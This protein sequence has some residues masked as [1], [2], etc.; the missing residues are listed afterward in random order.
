M[1]QRVRRCRGSATV[2][3]VVVITLTVFV[4]IVI[5]VL[6]CTLIFAREV[7]YT[8][9]TSRLRSAPTQCTNLSRKA[10]GRDGRRDSS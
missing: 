7:N 3:I 2:V 6:K 9:I 1:A 4:V 10:T 5:V 8:R